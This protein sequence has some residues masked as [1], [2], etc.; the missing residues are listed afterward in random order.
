M[1]I[2]RPLPLLAAAEK[3]IALDDTSRERQHERE[4]HFRSRRGEHVGRVG[5]RDPAPLALLEVDVIETDGIVG[6]HA[7]LRTGG[8]QQVRRQ[9]GRSAS[10]RGHH[11]RPRA[12]AAP[13][14]GGGSSESWT[15]SANDRSSSL[16]TRSGTRRVAEDARETHRLARR[17]PQE[18]PPG[19]HDR[20]YPCSVV[21]HFTVSLA[22]RR[23]SWHDRHRCRHG[24]SIRVNGKASDRA[25]C[26]SRPEEL[27]RD[28]H[29]ASRRNARSQ[30]AAP[31]SPEPRKR[32]QCRR[33]GLACVAAKSWTKAVPAGAEAFV[34]EAGHRYVRSTCSCVARLQ[35]HGIAMAAGRRASR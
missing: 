9:R 4:R 17:Q 8:V 28:E 10:S 33:G 12:R 24:I 31:P 18:A 23:S 2:R 6:D 13:H 15:S 19:N 22:P 5:D 21:A 26:K 34:N 7:Q 16:S 11:T 1:N 27:T 14:A 29:P 3:A 35:E 32:R 30:P 25:G 20:M